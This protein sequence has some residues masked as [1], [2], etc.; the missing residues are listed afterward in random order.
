MTLNRIIKHMQKEHEK[1][2][3]NGWISKP[4]S[5]ALYYTWKWCNSI[6]E[7]RTEE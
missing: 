4:W 6:E 2:K 1:A 5:W 3:N 7:E